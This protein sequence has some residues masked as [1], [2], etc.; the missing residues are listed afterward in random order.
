MHRSLRI[1]P[2]ILL[3]LASPA[4][5]QQP[6]PVAAPVPEAPFTRSF[7]FTPL[8]TSVVER[9]LA[10]TVAGTSVVEAS[11]STAAIPAKRVIALS[12][13]VFRDA[14]DWTAWINGKKVTPKTL[15]PEIMD[16]RA[17]KG[18]VHLKWFD[19]GINGV[20]AITLRP[21][22]TYDIVTGVLLPG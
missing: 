9:A 1:F 13:L 22:Q 11:K 5:A 16:I 14:D 15:L 8:E 7:L 20:I 4:W 18:R 17:E 19:I 3:L 12:G 10:G 21:H 2:A 6:A